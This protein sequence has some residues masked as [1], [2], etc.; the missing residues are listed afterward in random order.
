MGFEQIY[1][2]TL[3]FAFPLGT[4]DTVITTNSYTDVQNA[5]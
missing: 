5:E 3:G 1:P 4:T 2:P